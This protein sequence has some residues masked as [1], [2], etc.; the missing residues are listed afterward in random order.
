MAQWITRLP[1]EQKILGSTPSWLV[2]ASYGKAMLW[3]SLIL[4]VEYQASEH[5][6]GQHSVRY[7]RPPLEALQW[8]LLLPLRKRVSGLTALQGHHF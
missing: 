6:A 4:G 3:H 7:Q 1:T 8:S 5:L 2:V